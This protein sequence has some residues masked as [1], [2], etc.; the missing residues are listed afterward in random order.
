MRAENAPRPGILLAQTPS[1]D[2]LALARLLAR[3]LD[4]LDLPGDSVEI[5]CEAL[6]V[7]GVPCPHIWVTRLRVLSGDGS[8]GELSECWVRGAREVRLARGARIAGP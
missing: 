3:V 2:D 1:M 6:E 7:F 4:E 8:V 5:Y